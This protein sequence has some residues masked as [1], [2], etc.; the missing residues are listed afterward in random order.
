[1]TND[2]E[3]R[4]LAR[5]GE[6][7]VRSSDDFVRGGKCVMELLWRDAAEEPAAGRELIV[8][9]GSGVKVYP[10][11]ANSRM[12]WPSFVRITRT[13]FWAYSE[14]ILPET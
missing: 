6:E 1:M 11:P 4:L 14:D 5:A 8:R 10:N 7:G 3:T 12:A 9:C 2:L 13:V